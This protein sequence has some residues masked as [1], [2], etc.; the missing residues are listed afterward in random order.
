M[1]GRA[2]ICEGGG[3]LIQP[4][5]RMQWRR[6]LR[7]NVTIQMLVRY[8][9]LAPNLYRKFKQS[10]KKIVL[11]KNDCH[12][13]NYWYFLFQFLENNLILIL[14]RILKPKIGVIGSH[15][16]SYFMGATFQGGLWGDTLIFRF[17]LKTKV[18]H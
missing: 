12:S 5:T 16:V 8:Q 2:K 7:H 10:L 18:A 1:W 6:G 4:H 15:G 11:G 9:N 13:V 17:F 14:I 3:L